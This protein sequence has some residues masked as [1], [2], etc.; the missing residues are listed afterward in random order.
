MIRFVV[1][2]IF[3]TKVQNKYQ[4]MT[5]ALETKVVGSNFKINRWK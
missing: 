4:L 1:L 3:L 2:I 5:T